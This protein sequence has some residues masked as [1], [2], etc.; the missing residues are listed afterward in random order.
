M[1]KGFAFLP[2]FL[3]FQLVCSS[4]NLNETLNVNEQCP[5][6]FVPQ[7]S[8]GTVTC[9]C[10]NSGIGP[11]D[12]LCDQSSNSSMLKVGACM[13]YDEAT[14]ETVQGPCPFNYHRP[15][16]N[17]EYVKLP[18]DV[19]K[20]NEFM[21][22]GLNR[23]GVLCSH[24]QPGL[25]PVVFSYTLQCMKCLDSGYGWLLY[26]FLATFPTTLLFI[27]LMFC[28]IRITAAPLNSFTFVTQTL[29]NVVNMDPYSF[30]QAS[31]P[32]HKLTVTLLTLFGVVN[33]DFFAYVI[34]PFCVST[35]LS[36]MQALSLK[37]IEAFY[38]ILLA[39]ILYT[40]IQ[41]HARGCRIL[42]WLWSPFH[43]CCAGRTSSWNPISSLVHIFASFILLSYSKIL[44][45]SC[46]SLRM[47]T[48][49]FIPSNRVENQ[50]YYNASIPNFSAEHLPFAVFAIFTLFIFILMPLLLLLLYPSRIFQKCLDCCRVRWHALHIFA[51][52]FQGQYKDGT[53]GTPDWRY[54]A[55]FYLIFRIV[56]ISSYLLPC[57]HNLI[58]IILLGA[59]SLLFALLRPYK[60]NW[61]NIWDS[62]AFALY[63]FGE[64]GSVYARYVTHSRFDIAYG[65]AVIPILYI[66]LYITYQVLLRMGLRQRCSSVI[67]KLTTQR[68]TLP[69]VDNHYDDY[70][71]RDDFPDRVAHPEQYEPL[72]PSAERQGT[73][74]ESVEHTSLCVDNGTFP[75][76]GNSV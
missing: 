30:M 65:L 70:S 21:C 67:Q 40:C 29:M 19:T 72:L 17:Q 24:C 48:L 8:K 27:I 63:C 7:V 47:S 46:M 23:T 3:N 34:P 49:L 22:G 18:Q 28:Q 16:V 74:Y 41:L 75:A 15:D 68:A 4:G 55:G 57:H 35:K 73:R 76:C 58:R 1:Y 42:V 26:I 43:K 10:A 31:G 36:T 54:F 66:I 6:W 53:T 44:F 62:V 51:D 50:I 56:I 37:Y 38:P 52:A 71:D 45:V 11:D 5:T 13:T 9:S 14:N 60:E 25:G 69:R 64:L 59:G 32:I 61:I 39:V 2:L 20:L 33:L 12:V